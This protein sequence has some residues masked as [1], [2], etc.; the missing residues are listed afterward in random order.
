LKNEDNL[1]DTRNEIESLEKVLSLNTPLTTG[2]VLKESLRQLW[3]KDDFEEALQSLTG[4]REV[5]SQYSYQ[6]FGFPRKDNREAQ[7]RP[8]ERL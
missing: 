2:Y 5:S 1:D 4:I 6:H 7:D 3:K 8:I